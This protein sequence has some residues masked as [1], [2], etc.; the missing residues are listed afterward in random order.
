M[1]FEPAYG[2]PV[3]ALITGDLRLTRVMVHQPDRC[4]S[5]TEYAQACGLETGR[6]IEMLG[7]LLD[8]G[9][10]SLEIQGDEIFVHTGAA[11][12]PAPA[13]LM[14]V[15]V[16]LWERLR[17]GN[18]P[19]EAFTL[20]KLVRALQASGWVVETNQPR[21]MFGKGQVATLPRI[22][23]EVGHTVVPVLVFPSAGQVSS[24]SGLLEQY[25]RAGAP[26]VAITCDAGALDAMVTAARQWTMA[27]A[28]APVMSVLILE[29]PRYNPTLISPADGAVRPLTVNRAV[30]DSQDWH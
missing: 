11:G 22:G 30:L 21:I 29:A 17:A 3:R 4:A 9:A 7:D 23:V 25:H 2:A 19:E 24:T 13:N 16:N 8:S 14:P 18:S 15:P 12:R 5:V 28:I 20:W 10:I 26:A 6:V 27:H 1:S